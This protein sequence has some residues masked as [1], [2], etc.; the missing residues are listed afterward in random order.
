MNR[1]QKGA[2]LAELAD[3][4]RQQ[5]S[6]CGETHL[7]KATYFLQE[8]LNVP[9]GFDFILYKHGP[10]S[11]DLR[12]ELTS[13]RAD[14]LL[15][16]RVQPAPYG[17]SLLPS[18]R[19]I[20]YRSRFQVTI[21]NYSGAVA[22]IARVLG[23]KGVADLESLGTALLVTRQL[24]PTAAVEDRARRLQELK[25]HLSAAQALS[26]VQEVDEIARQ[27]KNLTPAQAG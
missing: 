19:S 23:K 11:F 8:L 25:P 21:G 13:L 15:E 27:A 5:G 26:A 1:L 6:W 9:T 20:E 24:G 10:F 4:L 17:P 7:Q 16:L 22:F 14:G 2:L 12:D 3:Q 18:S